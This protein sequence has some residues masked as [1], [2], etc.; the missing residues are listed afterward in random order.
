MPEDKGRTVVG[1]IE[2]TA[3]EDKV[4]TA[5]EQRKLQAEGLK[6]RQYA[7]DFNPNVPQIDGDGNLNFFLPNYGVEEYLLDRASW[8]KQLNTITGEPGWFYF[9]IFFNFNTE[10][11][12]LGGIL[13]G[14]G[15]G[16]DF[17][18]DNSNGHPSV[19]TA[20]NYLNSI[21]NRYSSQKIPDRM[22]ALYKF[23]GTLSY[24]SCEAPWFFKGISGLNNIKGAYTSDFNK[25][26]NITIQ[27]SE[28]A[29]DMRL[30]TL[31][32]L[33]KYACYDNINCKEIIPSNLRKFDMAILVFHVPIK[34]YQTPIDLTGQVG[35]EVNGKPI[36]KNGNGQG[37]KRIP[38]T[39]EINK[40]ARGFSNSIS[41]KLYSFVNCEIDMES[42][43]PT[44]GDSIS[45]EMAFTTG[46][47]G[48]KINYDRVYEH[49]M[50]EWSQMMFGTDGFYY[51]VNEPNDN[52]S[53][54]GGFGN[55][56]S[57]KLNDMD[58]KNEFVARQEKL[59]ELIPQHKINEYSEHIIS[60][61][62]RNL[63]RNPD[64]AGDSKALGE[65]SPINYQLENL[66][67]PTS[68][69]FRDKLVDLKS[70]FGGLLT[71]YSNG[72][73]YGT[74]TQVHS[75]YYSNKL[76][77]FKEGTITDGNIYQY[78]LGRTGDMSNRKNTQYLDK[79]LTK[80]K[81]G[82]IENH[83]NIDISLGTKND[84][85]LNYNSQAAKSSYNPLGIDG[86][87]DEN[88]SWFRNLIDSVWGQTKSTFGF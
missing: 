65:Y 7:K 6:V 70:P 57:Y 79:K 62:I 27:C 72:N 32:D 51:N 24:I 40:E 1:G 16:N 38:T 55:T 77:Y 13:N 19:N 4:L 41:F 59:I 44:E 31:L 36:Y 83:E 81:E 20:I 8:Q 75:H 71:N 5:A 2:V 88:K 85:K 17:V 76:K 63:S 43:N 18:D 37:F 86:L 64:A 60:N 54:M 56:N 46:K 52:N 66:N 35:N 9:K 15:Y 48:I 87:Y 49:R 73:L 47:N 33:Y 11:G 25:N 26:K 69:Y 50:N 74:F 3:K 34:F 30:G 39:S 14:P 29:V 67:S 82:N 68:A 21:K 80:L 84:L 22:L 12:L 10:Y 58:L 53:F 61:F 42:L 45:N 28:D 78:D 23:V